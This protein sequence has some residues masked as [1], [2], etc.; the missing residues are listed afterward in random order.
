MENIDVKKGSLCDGC[1]HY[2]FGPIDYC[3][4]TGKKE[5]IYNG[6]DLIYCPENIVIRILEKGW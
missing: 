5:E 3:D 1:D 2:S 4:S 6:G